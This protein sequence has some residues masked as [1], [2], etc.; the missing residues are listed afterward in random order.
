[1]VNWQAILYLR[2]GEAHRRSKLVATSY[3]THVRQAE[4]ANINDA[5]PD[6]DTLHR[7]AALLADEKLPDG[8]QMD[9]GSGY[10]H[11]A[12]H[13]KWKLFYREF[14]PRSPAE[15]FK[16]LFKGSDAT[17]AWDNNQN[18]LWSGFSAPPTVARGTLPNDTEYIFTGIAKGERLST[19]I[20]QGCNNEVW[21][22]PIQ[23]W[24]LLRELGTFV[25]RLHATGFIHGDLQTLNILTYQGP[26]RFEFSLINNEN[27]TQIQPVPGKLL[28]QNLMQLNLHLPS[29]ISRSD[30]LRFFRAWHSQMRDLS[31][32]EAKLLARRSYERAMSQLV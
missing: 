30:R 24:A 20:K 3:F 14:P 11:V 23:K 19:W 13:E 8:W 17:R 9:T 27:N 16:A 22:R 12:H 18:L 21:R 28:L 26:S 4:A 32:L 25:G 6:Q 29:E 15:K 5:Q 2:S 7:C 31:D 10:T 1:M